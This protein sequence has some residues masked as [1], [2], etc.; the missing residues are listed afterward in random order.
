MIS[1]PRKTASKKPVKIYFNLEDDGTG[2]PP[3]STEFL[4]CIPTE[5]GTYIVDNI[6]FFAREISLGDEVS[7]KR[8]GRTLHFSDIVRRSTN[9]T[10]RVLLKKINKASAIRK[11][12]DSFGCFTELMDELGLLAVSM[13][14]NSNIAESLSFLDEEAEKG[15]VGIEE[16]AVRYK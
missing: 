3:T 16:S 10:V 12:L 8:S 2:Y 5:H 7:A 1:E 11:K 6:P 14:P 9:S 4:W 13:P 15:T